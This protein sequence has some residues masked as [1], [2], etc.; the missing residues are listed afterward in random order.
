MCFFSLLNLLPIFLPLGRK[1]PTVEPQSCLGKKTMALRAGEDLKFQ[2]RAANVISKWHYILYVYIYVYIH[3]R[4]RYII[5]IYIYICSIVMYYSFSS[6]N[7]HPTKNPP[8][9][10]WL[11][12]KKATKTADRTSKQ[13]L[14]LNNFWA[15][16]TGGP[17]LCD[18]I[19]SGEYRRKEWKNY[20]EFF[21]SHL[22]SYIGVL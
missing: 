1:N 18:L 14:Q 21:S 19:W 3:Y 2:N 13:G 10:N 17:S 12:Q 5:T 11:T 15:S 7:H 6:S 20:I 8:F 22:G 16:L 4:Y 9:F